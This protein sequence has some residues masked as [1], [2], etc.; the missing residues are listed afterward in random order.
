MFQWSVRAEEAF[1]QL[2]QA[3]TTTPVLAL[4]DF[5][6]PFIIESDAYGGGIGAV[7]M[8]EGRPI[9]Y[10]SKMLGPKHLSL[11][12][13]EKEMMAIIHAVH[14]W[15]PYL[16]ARHFVIRTDHQSLKYFLD[17]PAL[18]PA[19][20]KWVGK[21]VGYDYEITYRRGT[22]NMAADA[23][24]RIHETPTVM[25][26]SSPQ[27]DWLD[28]LKEDMSTNPWIREIIQKV[29]AGHSSVTQYSIIDGILRYKNRIVV[30]ATSNWRAKVLFDMHST[31]IAGH[32][33]YLR[34]YKRITR[35]FYWPGMK[36][37]VKQFVAE[38][39]TCQ[40]NKSEIVAPPGLL[41]PLQV[42]DRV[43]TD[44]SMD[45]IEGLPVSKGKDVIFVVVDR[46]SKYAHFVP[47][48]HPFTASMVAQAFV[49]N[50]FKLHGMPQ[51]IVSDRDKIFLSNFWK[52]FF[53]Y[54]VLLY[55]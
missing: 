20:Q 46:L 54:K 43:W 41:Q 25:A 53:R 23:L 12:T 21:L 50:V 44:I 40:R 14:K 49:D 19:Q 48:S 17:S 42:P 10:M 37:D 51:T 11:S 4:P 7:L 31:P 29:E 55:V 30:G 3:M 2:K 15:R 45:F 36:K 39:D 6:K 47:L 26:L 1:Q 28:E 16:L 34:T 9:A 52:E 13:Y 5:S 38:C 8:Q 18:T 35:S 32:T 22:E 24:S 33:G 27:L